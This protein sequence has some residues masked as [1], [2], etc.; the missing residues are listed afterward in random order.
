MRTTRLIAGGAIALALCLAQTAIAQAPD[1]Q[2]D[3]PAAQ[4][5]V[6]N[7]APAKKEAPRKKPATP[8]ASA[9]AKPTAPV[10]SSTPAATPAQTASGKPP[11][12]AQDVRPPAN[13]LIDCAKAPKDAVT[14]LPDE[15]AR[16]AT[17]YCTKFGHIFN[18]NDKYFGAFPDNGTR[19]SFNA[20]DLA[21]KPPS[22]EPGNSAYFTAIGYRQLSKE[23]SADLI[24]RDPS[25]R[26]ILE[27]KPLWR[28][29]LTAIGG[30]NL[31]FIVIDPSADPFWV[32]PVGEKGIATP[33]FYV[34]SLDALNKAR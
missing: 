15:L 16:W 10:K 18:A 12:T 23:E 8:R 4:E 3:A 6:P 22:G 21:G 29:D 28:L 24:A 14:K 17:V 20:A 9:P 1:E 32:F 34:T 30:Q 25:V 27:N 5:T 33:A 31:S 2:D 26:R 13:V 7:E 19:A 11:V